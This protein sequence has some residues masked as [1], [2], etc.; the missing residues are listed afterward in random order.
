MG[1]FI[2]IDKS[3]IHSLSLDEIHTLSEHYSIV[4]CPMLIQEICGNLLEDPSDKENCK[5]KV[6]YLAKKS[7][8]L[9]IG[10]FSIGPYQKIAIADLFYGNIPM[11]CQIPRFDGEEV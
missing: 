4:V 9:I 2:L 10:V 11:K 3:V 8:G 1:P 7:R 6:A 5:Q